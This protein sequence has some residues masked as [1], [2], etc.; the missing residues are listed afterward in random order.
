MVAT[1]CAVL[2]SGDLGYVDLMRS[3]LKMLL[4]NSITREDGH[5]LV[6][7]R[8]GPD[9]W[10]RESS[11]DGVM[12]GPDSLRVYEPVHVYHMSMS[13][14]D[15]DLIVRL[16]EGDKERDWNEVTFH[17]DRRADWETEYSRFSTTTGRT[18][19]GRKRRW[20]PSTSRRWTRMSG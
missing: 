11:G 2:L 20:W 8:I 9:G 5:L 7:R 4:D 15:Y 19:T 3:Q 16:R 13:K 17:G 6:P 1:E 18:P 12:L 10:A 14:E